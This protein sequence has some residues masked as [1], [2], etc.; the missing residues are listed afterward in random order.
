MANLFCCL[1]I[2]CYLLL[3]N[4]HSRDAALEIAC[5]LEREHQRALIMHLGRGIIHS[6]LFLEIIDRKGKK[7][8]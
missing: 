4:L 1:S 8:L 3:F 7:I 5:L 2:K 6:F